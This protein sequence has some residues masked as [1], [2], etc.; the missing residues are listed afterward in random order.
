MTLRTKLVISFTTL[1]LVVIAAVGL[2]VTRSVE[3][4]LVAQI[5]RVLTGFSERGPAPSLLPPGAPDATLPPDVVQLDPLIAEDDDVQRRD[6]AEVLINADGEVVFARPSGFS[7]DTDPLPDVSDL[8]ETSEPVNLPSVDGSLEYRAAILEMPDGQRLVR[9]IPLSDVDNAT[10]ALVQTLLITGAAVVL[11]GGAATWWTVRRSMRP[12]DQMVDTAEAIAAGD[13]TQRVSDLNPTTELGSLAASI[14]A[15]LIHIEGALQ[16]E[17]EAQE[18]LRQFVAD[19]SHELR[20]PLSAVSGYAQLGRK[21]GLDTPESLDNAWSRI[22]SESQRMGRLIEDL[23]ML[24]RLGQSQPL[25]IEEIDLAQ[26]S[27]DAAADHMAIDSERPIA[28]VGAESIPIRGDNQRLHQVISNLLANARVHTPPRISP[29][30]KPSVR[31]SVR[32]SWRSMW[33]CLASSAT[34]PSGR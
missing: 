33:T 16:S 25:E 19:A 20:T 32:R 15:M 7:D 5:D 14:N 30:S 22:E 18:R 21:G 10:A 26:L 27:R 23:L 12:I 1:L 4:T 8:P 11:V 31:A 29:T 13:L 6:D 3:T 9:A 24:A 2:V 17:R 28:V 34:A